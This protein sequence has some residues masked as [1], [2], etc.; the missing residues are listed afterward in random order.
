MQ[1]KLLTMLF[2]LSL[3]IYQY[4]KIVSYIGCKISEINNTVARCDCEKANGDFTSNSAV[5]LQKL[6]VKEKVDDIFSE[7]HQETTPLIIRTNNQ[8]ASTRY[9]ALAGGFHS[10]IFEP[11]RGLSFSI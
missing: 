7:Q 1:R 2:I 4:G 5:P 6:V 11:P 10:S 3:G 9:D 8:N